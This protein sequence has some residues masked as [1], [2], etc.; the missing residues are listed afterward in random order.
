MATESRHRH[1]PRISKEAFLVAFRV[2]EKGSATGRKEWKRRRTRPF[3]GCP[4]RRIW[5]SLSLSLIDRRRGPGKQQASKAI[6]TMEGSKE[7]DALY[8]TRPTRP[9]TSPAPAGL[10][11]EET[12]GVY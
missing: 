4:V 2:A 5:R 1:E 6:P 10:C 11:F 8:G 7:E 12:A 9:D 3:A